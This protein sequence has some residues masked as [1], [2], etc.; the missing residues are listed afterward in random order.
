MKL[1]GLLLAAAVFCSLAGVLYW[2]DHRKPTPATV[3]ADTP[4][5]IL[6]L[7]QR[8]IT[9]VELKK[10]GA[11][12]I[13]L[14]K[15]GTDWKITAPKNLNADP[16]VVSGMLST[17]SSLNSERVIEDKATNLKQYGLDPASFQAD[18]T[19]KNNKTQQLMIGDA[20]PTGNA[21]YVE[22]AGD[23]RVFTVPNYTESEIDRS[24]N[25]LRDKQLVTLSADKV[26]QLELSGKNGNIE[27]GRSKDEWQILKPKPMRANSDEVGELV[28]KI[29][30]ARMNLTGPDSDEKQAD[31]GFAHG[32]PVVSAKVT[33]ESG[34]QEL[35]IRK[36]KDNYYAKSSIVAGTYKVDSDLPTA[37]DKK[38]DDFRNKKVFDFGYNT[39]NKI[40]M[41]DGSKAYF[42]THSGDDWWQDGKKMDPADVDQVLGDLR[43]LTATKFVDSGFKN[44]EIQ[45][46]VTS[47]DG[48]RTEKV[49][50]AKAGDGYL[51]RREGEP[52]L[53][54]LDSGPVQDLL[55]SAGSLKAAPAAPKK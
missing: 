27:F 51:A 30:N 9:R 29:T 5:P 32:T 36:D 48:K 17:L 1:G 42:L 33:S 22:L 52:T 16:T 43:D 35:Q 14:S 38:V 11:D 55:K 54:L 24:L 46:T 47:N 25:D 15:D 34:T 20:T 40:E 44:P 19:E 10:P 37:L 28:S 53:Y 4:P 26:S 39:P 50:L 31:A 13:V 3:S 23:P 18:V 45:L 8:S 12:P 6:K 21:H 7:D 41:H 2:S 49:D